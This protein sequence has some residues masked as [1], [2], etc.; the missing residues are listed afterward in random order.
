MAIKIGAP[1][2]K[3]IL[4]GGGISASLPIYSGDYVVIP[5]AEE[6]Q[7]L[8]TSGY[9]MANDVTV[10]EIPYFEVKNVAGGMTVTIG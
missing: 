5:K 7:I 4:G 9:A 8:E 3:V 1:K 10:K 6:E 2:G